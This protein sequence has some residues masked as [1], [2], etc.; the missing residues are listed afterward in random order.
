VRS[1]VIARWKVLSWHVVSEK[2]DIP[3]NVLLQALEADS[4]SVQS[5]QECGK[6]AGNQF[7]EGL[8]LVMCGHVYCQSCLEER[9]ICLVC[10]QSMT[11]NRTIPTWPIPK[12]RQV[13]G[14]LTSSEAEIRYGPEQPSAKMKYVLNFLTDESARDGSQKVIIF[15][16]WV[17]ALD[18]LKPIIARQRF[19]VF[20]VDGRMQMTKRAQ[21]I[22][23]F[24][25]H[26]G[27]A[28][29]LMS[30]LTGALGLNM[31]FASHVIIMDLWWN[32]AIEAQ[33]I[34]RVHR[35]GQD[36]PVFIKKLMIENT[37]EDKVVEIQQ[38]KLRT[39]AAAY[40]GR[41]NEVR[42]TND[43]LMQLFSM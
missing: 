25:T 36:K 22:E 12:V 23:R 35:I 42:F 24:K 15:S 26:R 10:G 1:V 20:Q 38:R 28:V 34:D 14:E 16:Q 5:C 17:C 37:V 27:F 32:P 18:V 8:L 2:Y 11:F 19:A 33:A 3:E 40:G 29:I 4:I 13:F 30:L 41:S 43:D 21:E 31:T 9:D 7:G 6:D 39:I